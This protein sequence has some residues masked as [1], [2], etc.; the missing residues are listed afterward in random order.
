MLQMLRA[1]SCVQAEACKLGLCLARCLLTMRTLK[2]SF[3]FLALA[4]FCVQT[5]A[6]AAPEPAHVSAKASQAARPQATDPHRMP[7]KKNLR[8]D[9]APDHR[10][11]R[12]MDLRMALMPQNSNLNA[13]SGNS[14]ARSQGGLANIADMST[15]ESSPEHH[16][17]AKERQEMRELLRQQRL[18]LQGGPQN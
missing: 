9:S 18:M 12:G 2:S 14:N 10:A 13:G 17:N 3:Y 7:E 15:P 11:K 16:L 8:P 5:F 1:G 6:Q 4:V